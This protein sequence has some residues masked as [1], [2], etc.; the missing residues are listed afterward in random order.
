MAETFKEHVEEHLNRKDR[1]FEFYDKV[2]YIEKQEIT[3]QP[4]GK[5]YNGP[6]SDDEGKDEE[7]T[8]LE[9]ELMPIFFNNIKV[10]RRFVRDI[11]GV[12]DAGIAEI[13]NR[14]IADDKILMSERKKPLYDVLSKYKIYNAS[15]SN[16]KAMV[17]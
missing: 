10:V 17:S 8:P 15:L 7:P 9:M 14:Y 6:A 16:F 11:N 2:T 1:K 5:F 3:V 12:S 13:I 4:G